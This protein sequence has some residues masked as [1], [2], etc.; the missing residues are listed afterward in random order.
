MQKSLEQQQAS[1]D[2]FRAHAQSASLRQQHDS[3]LTQ[4]QALQRQA[5]SAV[6]ASPSNS[7]S[8]QTGTPQT[9][10]FFS[11]PWPGTLPLSM[12]NIQIADESCEALPATEIDK[13]VQSAARK[14]GLDSLLLR[15][16]MK[17]ESAFKPCA[18]S[19]AGAMGLMQIMPETAD[20]LHV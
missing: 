20:M 19:V 10:D 13:L 11:V 9:S 7:A 4:A 6:T 5:Q 8:S 18:L 15:S 3:L 12:P 14:H 17:Q 2:D 1:L 16:V